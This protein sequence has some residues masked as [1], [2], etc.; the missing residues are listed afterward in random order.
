MPPPL[1]SMTAELSQPSNVY[2][3]RRDPD[4]DSPS[5][6]AT[7]VNV[8]AP[9]SL[10]DDELIG[11]VRTLFQ[12]AR[13]ARK[14]IINQWNRNHRVMR[15]RTWTS[16]L[17]AWMPAPEVPEIR[18]II[19]S[20]VAWVTDQRPDFDV[21][22]AAQPFSPFYD[23][24]NSLAVDMKTAMNAAWVSYRWES[25][26]EKVV[27]DGYQWGI[28]WLTVDWDPTL[29]DGLGDASLRRVDPW[30]IYVDPAA[31]SEAD[32]NYIIE[33]RRISLQELDRK[34]PGAARKFGVQGAFEDIDEAPQTYR[35]A[36]QVP[37][38]NPGA[39][40]PA[41]SA[42]WGLPGQA[43]ISTQAADDTAGVTLLKCWLREHTVTKNDD[44]TTKVY[45]SWRCVVIAGP[46]VLLNKR[47][48]DILPFP[49]HPF[50]RYAPEDFGELYSQSMV[51][52]LA[53]SQLSINRLL[54]SF[55]LA[56][57]LT[58]NPPFVEDTRS[59][60]Q[61]TK[62]TPNRPGQRISVA[63]GSRADWMESRQV[64][65]SMMEGVRFFIGEMRNISGLSS[66]AQ[67]Q[68]PGGRN[69]TDVL[70]NVLEAGFVRI[71]L[72]LRNL[73]FA[74]REAGELVA[75][76]ISEFY[77]EPRMVS[78]V[79]PSGTKTSLAVRGRHFYCTTDKGAIPMRFQLQVRAGSSVPTSR[80]ARMAEA[81]TLFAMGGI[82]RRALLDAHDFPNRELIL[83]RITQAEQAGLFSPPG[84][85]QRAG[86]TT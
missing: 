69:S 26:I 55:L 33:A 76:M 35:P 34:F 23:F 22:P 47:A 44:G 48:E 14:P 62:L 18:P 41:T 43:R 42:R 81:D 58:A 21:A 84:A 28:G 64:N 6:T 57:D 60:T 79:G 24:Y 7:P 63:P 36:G 5:P 86:R 9:P 16:D 17:A 67:A 52:L 20:C 32:M 73:E 49:R 29:A 13:A 30:T 46:H 53:S 68:A 75:S 59:G 66:I 39:V 65:P 82:D 77:T 15:N 71:R 50:V 54:Q 25:E 31:T 70:D 38:S 10:A 45:D 19:A 40:A 80:G 78:M 74:L 11:R 61:R 3:A 85:R 27:W 1:P 4:G 37:R 56:I 12:R 2:A 8:E 51:E 83:E 72:A